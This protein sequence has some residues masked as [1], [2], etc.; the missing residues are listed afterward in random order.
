MESIANNIQEIDF[1]LL[2]KI[3]L[4]TQQQNRKMQYNQ[5]GES[6]LKVS[7]ICLGTMTY[8]QQNTIEEAHQQL[9]YSIAQGINFIDAAEMYPVPTQAETYGLTEKYIGEWLKHQQRDNQGDSTLGWEVQY[10]SRYLALF[11]K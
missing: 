10:F 5:L 6:D 4:T 1:K 7:D 2:R 8:G 9:D 3:R 11:D